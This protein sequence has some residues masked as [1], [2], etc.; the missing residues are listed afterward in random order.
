MID[1]S[2]LIL[3]PAGVFTLGEPEC[4]ADHVA[5]ASYGELEMLVLA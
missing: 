5:E 4:P 1:T 3:I 2:S